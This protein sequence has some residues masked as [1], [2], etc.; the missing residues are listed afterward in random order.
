MATVVRRPCERLTAEERKQ[1][2]IDV[3]V[4]LVGMYGVQGASTAKIAEAAGV[5]EKTLYRHF[6]N[7]T[8][9]L[10]SALDMVF[11]TA[12]SVL[13]SNVGASAIERLRAIGQSQWARHAD[14]PNFV[15]P[16]FEFMVA[17][18]GVGLREH[19][20]ERHQENVKL[21]TRIIE[22]GKAQGVIREDVGPDRAAW[23]VFAVLFAADVSHLV[24]VR[25]SQIS[26]F[27]QDTWEQMLRDFSA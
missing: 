26:D 8:E 7:R 6:A 18:P 21:I 1:R 25:P 19:L 4:E 24:G 23:R 3:T 5:N 12:S 14:E 16:L 9:I 10:L 15:Y 22:E 13:Q 17:P 27:A 11:D 20:K 2:I